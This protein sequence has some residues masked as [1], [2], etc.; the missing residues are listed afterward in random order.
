MSIVEDLI[1]RKNIIPPAAISTVSILPSVSLLGKIRTAA[2]ASLRVWQCGSLTNKF[3]KD[4]AR[5]FGNSEGSDERR[6][7][8]GCCAGGAAG[9]SRPGRP[10]HDS[11]LPTRRSVLCSEIRS[12]LV[13]CTSDNILSVHRSCCTCVFGSQQQALYWWRGRDAS[14]KGG[15][16]VTSCSPAWRSSAVFISPALFLLLKKDCYTIYCDISSWWHWWT[17]E[18]CRL[19]SGLPAE[20][21]RDRSVYVW[22]SPFAAEGGEK[23]ALHMFWAL[24]QLVLIFC[25]VFW[26]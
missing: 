2:V 7:R 23:L 24:Q 8:R 25:F 13:L 3:T 10:A 15:L 18:K 4:A 9:G 26:V 17:S 19:V 6:G 5:V 22:C 12:Q 20:M 16:V 14:G 11:L 21:F 1:W